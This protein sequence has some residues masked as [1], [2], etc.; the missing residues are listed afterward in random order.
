MVSLSY[1]IEQ[2]DSCGIELNG[3]NS[4]LFLTG[5]NIYKS[6]LNDTVGFIPVAD[7]IEVLTIATG[8]QVVH[9]NLLPEFV[10][11]TSEGTYGLNYFKPHDTVYIFLP[12]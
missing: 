8:G 2:L 10:I 11:T 5:L 7:R 12:K 6:E 4:W 9:E 3:V 1:I